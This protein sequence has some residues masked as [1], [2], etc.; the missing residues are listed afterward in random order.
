[1]SYY[2]PQVLRWLTSFQRQ[3][4]STHRMAAFDDDDVPVIPVGGYEDYEEE[5]GFD[6]AFDSAQSSMMQAGALFTVM[7]YSVALRAV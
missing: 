3:S 6:S 7:T 4:M 1:M 2:T 5:T